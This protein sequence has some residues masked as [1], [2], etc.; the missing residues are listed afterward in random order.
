MFQ[1]FKVARVLGFRIL[2]GFLGVKGLG[3]QD[4]NTLRTKQVERRS[5]MLRSHT[6]SYMG[7]KCYISHLGSLLITCGH[8]GHFTSCSWAVLSSTGLFQGLGF[9]VGFR[10]MHAPNTS[11]RVSKADAGSW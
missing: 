2:R 9:Q 5:R 6:M 11:P 1:G 4:V 7:V 3:F 8:F 10:G